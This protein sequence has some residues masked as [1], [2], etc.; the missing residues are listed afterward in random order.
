MKKYICPDLKMVD[1][2]GKTITI[3]VGVDY[4]K[5]IADTIIA[6]QEDPTNEIFLVIPKAEWEQRQVALSQL[7][8]LQSVQF[9]S[10]PTRGG[11]VVP[12]LK[13][14]IKEIPEGSKICLFAS[15]PNLEARI[16]NSIFLED[17]EV[18]EF[19]LGD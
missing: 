12:V 9:V 6:L 15:R 18:P 3:E 19:L 10:R 16:D 8:D 7:V 5:A 14:G 17:K 1:P 2:N 11:V 13:V 4:T